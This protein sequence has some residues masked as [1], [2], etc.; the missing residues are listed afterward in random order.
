MRQRGGCAGPGGPAGAAHGLSGLLE[1]RDAQRGTTELNWSA[2]LPNTEWTGVTVER[3]GAERIRR[4]T[5]EYLR[6]N[7][8]NGV[9]PAGLG[10]LWALRARELGFNRLTRAIPPEL[11]GTGT[12]LPSLQLTGRHPLPARAGLSATMPP[13]LGNPTGLRSLNLSNNRLTGAIPARL[14]RLV[15]LEELVL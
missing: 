11:G 14:S 12:G 10:R 3:F 7:G 13:Q 15:N 6:S 8:P 5:N 2:S 9:I 4:V 1:A